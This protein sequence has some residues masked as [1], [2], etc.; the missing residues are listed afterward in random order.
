MEPVIT[1]G[2]DGSPESLAAAYW[3]AREANLRGLSLRLMHAWVL[4]SPEPAGG[5]TA[6]DDPNYWPKRIVS[7]AGA[8]VHA[9]FP[10]LS[11]VQ[12][13]V[14][15]EPVDALLAAAQESTMLV[16]GSRSL[17]AVEGFFLGDTALHVASRAE[18]PVVLVR[19]DAAQ[20]A[21][22]PV[23]Q[24][25]DVVVALGLH[26]PDARLVEFAFDEAARRG[27]PLRAVHGRSLPVQA[28]APWGVDPDVA[29]EVKEAAHGRLE[30]ALRQWRQRFPDV[31]VESVVRLE[32]PARAVLAEAA[33][34][35]LLVVGRARHRAMGV[36][37][38]GA[39]AQAAVH[40]TSCP[41]AI[42]PQD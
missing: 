12:D 15:E 27:V 40:H 4:L 6:A 2:L 16:L 13:L 25:G 30:D 18:R 8:A 1:V 41:V 5:K 14:A 21:A 31:A 10:E 29:A 11:V 32:S 39:V 33:D 28:F 23:A 42:V 37:R 7:D 19:A 20:A 38:V 36:P 3:A 26:R 24:D 9:R 22:R 35:G 34:A 17:S